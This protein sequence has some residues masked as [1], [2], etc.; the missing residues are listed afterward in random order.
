MSKPAVLHEASRAPGGTDRTPDASPPPPDKSDQR[1]RRMFA[2]IA[3]RYDFLN[4]LL[5]LNIDRSWRRFTTRMVPPEPGVPVLDCC[6]G[7]ADLA[8]AYHRASGGRSTVVGA[9]FCH[10][11]LRLGNVKVRRAGA[12]DR[13]I[14]IEGDAQRLPFP[15]DTF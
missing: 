11:M 12:A 6:T 13:V 10:E 15:G 8:L 2:S 9:D 7:T 4:H 1:V 3:H 5:S 14:L